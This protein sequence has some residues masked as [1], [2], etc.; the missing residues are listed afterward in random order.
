MAAMIRNSNK[1]RQFYMG[2]EIQLIVYVIELQGINMGL[3]P[4]VY[5]ARVKELF[6]FTDN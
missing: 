4:A 5:N 2:L 1:H 6:I 3:F